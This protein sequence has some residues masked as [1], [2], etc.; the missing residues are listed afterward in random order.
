[1]LALLAVALAVIT[2]DP[3]WDALGT[4][5]IGLLLIVVAV[6]VA[7]E[8]KA[9][10]IGQSADPDVTVALRRFLEQRPEV[11]RVFN[12]ITFQLGN[13][14]M[15]A[16]KAQ[17]NQSITAKEDAINDIEKELKR[18]FPQVRWSFFEP[19]NAA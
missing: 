18:Q 11:A 3:M 8:V 5:A 16:V 6:F 14:L 10:L 1:V 9:M 7:I 15:V 2:G 4:L 13:D 17:L 19:D 12:L